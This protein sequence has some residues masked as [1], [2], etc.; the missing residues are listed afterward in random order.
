MMHNCKKC[1]VGDYGEE[2][3]TFSFKYSALPNDKIIGIQ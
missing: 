1:I 3:T 2:G